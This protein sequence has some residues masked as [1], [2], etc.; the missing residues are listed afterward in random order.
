MA[1]LALG[2]GRAVGLDL[3]PESGVAA[4]RWAAHNGLDDRF[5]VFVGPLDA[6]DAADFDCVVANLLKR[7]LLPL[8]SAIATRTRRG[9]RAIF[10]GMLAAERDEVVA[11]LGRAGFAPDD[12]RRSVD[13]NGDTWIALLMSRA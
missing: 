6:L 12:E 10:S 8:C 7:E 11:A 13:D 2:A 9:G 4:R 5:R 3:D 1:A